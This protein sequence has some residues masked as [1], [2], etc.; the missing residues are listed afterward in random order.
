MPPTLPGTYYSEEVI[1]EFQVVTSGGRAEFGRASAGVINIVTQSGTNQPRGR[2]YGF[3]RNDVFDAKNP[4]AT[5]EDPLSQNQVGLTYG[6]PIARDRTFWFANVEHTDQSKTGVIT[7]SQANVDA[8]N[9]VLDQT[10]FGGPRIATGDFPTGYRTFNL[11]GRVDHELSGAS[12]LQFRYGFYD[13]A[14]DNARSVGGLNTVSRG[15]RLDNVDNTAAV[16]WL[17]SFGP[18][19]L[20]EAR[21]QWTRSRLGAPGNDLIGPAVNI[22]GVASFGAST[23]SPTGRDLDVLQIADTYT[24]QGGS[25][26][27][28]AGVDVLLN[29]VSILFPGTIPGTYTFSNLANFERGIYTQFQ[30]AFG[31]PRLDQFNPN[32]GFFVQDEW[33][34]LAGLTLNAGLRYDLQWLED[35]VRLDANNVSPRVGV[36]W[37]PG[38]Q[39]TVVRASAGIYYDR[40]PLRA[41]SNAL[42]RDGVNY[43]VAVLSFGQQSAPPF[44]AV[45]PSFP[46]TLLTAITTMDPE[47]QNGRSEQ[48]GLQVERGIGRHFSATAGYSYLRGHR[49]IMSRNV[50]V[51]TLT[52]AQA[53]LLGIPNLGRP[54]PN[55]GNISNF[56]SI[57]DSWFNGFTVSSGT[58]NASW[59]NTRVSY[60][61]SRSEDTSGNA[62]FSSP[63]DANDIAAEKG[64]SDQD[65]R[66]RLVV[67]GTIGGSS[68]AV[69]LGQKLDRALA[70]I[71]V[72]YV[73]SY[74][75]G[76]PFNIVTGNDRNNDTNTNDRPVGVGRNTGR[77]DP[78]SS[79][80]LRLSRAFSVGA[81]RLEVMLEAF[82]VF[83]HVNI[84][85]LNNTYGTAVLPNTTFGQPTLAGDPRQMQIGVRWTF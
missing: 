8:I 21:V 76:V 47:I 27:F 31:D 62:F 19:V 67:S 52:A 82:N 83:N 20:N 60:T 2:A 29:N 72:G 25:H 48:L 42:Q 73:V 57:G 40:I 5:Q 36:A 24:M 7:V 77:Q 38:D 66:H 18:R 32:A 13:V 64:P 70:G 49:I 78:V 45:L 53:A 1:R 30:Q 6:G 71:Q 69:G 41:T 28:K 9:R 55:Y 3:F 81:Q 61:L 4:L 22:S 15:T 43:S 75:T 74:A 68:G 84:L 65:Q 26:L 54:N 50:N 63:Q 10:G 37:A 59:G 16:S 56:E 34:P 39:Q 17:S 85:A 51:P 44:P 33:R 14:S 23:T 79:V 11:F 58:R 46:S 35:P 12:R 80:D